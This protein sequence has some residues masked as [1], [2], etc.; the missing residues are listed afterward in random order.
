MSNEIV[1]EAARKRLNFKNWEAKNKEKR[2]EYKRKWKSENPEKLKIVQRRT[3][4]KNKY[5]ITLEQY[6]EILIAQGGHCFFCDRTPA[7]ERYGVL[8]VDHCHETGR[9]RGLLCMTHNRA[10]G[11]FG[12]NEEGLLKALNYVRGKK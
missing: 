11:V 1:S 2:L 4:L 5:G 3:Q 7:Q 6:D 10:I 12:D 9:I 8:A